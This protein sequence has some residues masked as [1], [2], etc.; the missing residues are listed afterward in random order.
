MYYR[1]LYLLIFGFISL[2]IC[3]AQDFNDALRLSMPGLGS[4]AR[5][6]GMGN[7]YI[8]QSDEFSGVYFNP[9]GLGLMRNFE[10]S[11]SLDRNGISNSVNFFNNNT[12]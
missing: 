11:G 10:F 5:A 12:Q 9:A 7:S 2:N 8:A 1:K 4:S 3:L 6:L